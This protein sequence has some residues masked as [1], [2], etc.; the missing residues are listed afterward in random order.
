MSLSGEI[1]YGL[2]S[3][4]NAAARIIGDS[5][6]QFVI[7]ININKLR[8]PSDLLHLMPAIL[9]PKMSNKI[10]QTH[11]ISVKIIGYSWEH[12]L[13]KSVALLLFYFF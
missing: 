7:E 2:G 5:L 10:H 13:T 9:F 8:L 6:S 11:E 4:T 3:D 1:G 12:Q